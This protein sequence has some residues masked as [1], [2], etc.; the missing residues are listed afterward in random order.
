MDSV[1]AEHFLLDQ[2]PIRLRSPIPTTLKTA[3]ASARILIE[4]EPI[5]QIESAEDNRGRIISWAVDF[6][7]KR[8]MDTGQWP[9]DYRWENFAKPTGRYLEIQLSHS[10]MSVSQV[11]DP[12]K[13]P[14]NV[15][16]RANG[17]L[18]NEP[19]FDLK[20]FA[21][22]RS[23]QG[24]PH[25]LLVHGHQEL[26]FAHLGV[27][28]SLHHRNYIYLTP[29]LMLMPH[30]VPAEAPS[31][32]DTDHEAAMTLKEEIEKWRRDHDE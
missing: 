20:E 30:E 8:L 9:F 16:F 18:N 22:E 23:V 27:P 32:E 4:A 5:L 2:M 6:A 15:I 1:S 13:Q 21:D 19:F 31:V 29:N 24:L 14:R 17:R 12:K 10:V 26:A 3:Y 11:S 28:H 25:F 7:F